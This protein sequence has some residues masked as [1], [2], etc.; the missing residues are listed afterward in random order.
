MEIMNDGRHDF[1]FI[2]GRW[3]V[4]NRKLV[5]PLDPACDEWV[6][7]GAHAVAEPILGGLSH[8][9][10]IWADAPPGGT[11]FE[12][13]TLRQFDPEAK[14]WRIWWASTRQPGHLDPPVEGAWS[15]GRGVFECD[16]VLG[17][18]PTRVRFVWTH[19]RPDEARW[20]QSFSVDGGAWRRNWVMELTRVA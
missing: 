12:G 8:V 5:D 19:D 2:F 14:V 13:Y 10:R 11:A 1:D 20:E 7:F 16:D 15:D 17:G 3:Q 6:E 18:R 4:L 9:D